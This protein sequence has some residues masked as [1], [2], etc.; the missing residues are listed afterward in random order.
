MSEGGRP[1]LISSGTGGRPAEILDN[2]ASG[3]DAFFSTNQSLVAADI[4]RGAGDIYDARV[5]G[6]F[7]AAAAPEQC[8][9]SE[10]QR[11]SP[12]PP[13]RPPASGALRAPPHSRAG[14]LARALR[15]CRKKHGKKERRRCVNKAKAKFGTKQAKSGGGR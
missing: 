10:C 13:F 4:D 1:H 9:E 12:P 5:E 8:A 6:G 14:R 11:V 7:P 15:G 2:S 3:E